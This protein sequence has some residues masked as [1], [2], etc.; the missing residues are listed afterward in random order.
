[1]GNPTKTRLDD[2]ALVPMFGDHP[3]ELGLEQPGTSMLARLRDVDVYRRLFPDAFPDGADAF[4]VSNV[5]RALATFERT[6]I[7]G[8]RPTIATTTIAT[9]PRSRQRRGEVSSCSS[10]SRCPVSAVTT[11]SIFPV[12]PILRDAT[13]V[14]CPRPQHGLYNLAGPLSYPVPTLVSTR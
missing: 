12:R 9:I 11:V 3:V 2:Q 1:M 14:G 5:T 7:S 10:V 13:K 6:I 4:T 8:D